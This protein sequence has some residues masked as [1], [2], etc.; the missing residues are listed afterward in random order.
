MDVG[1]FLKRRADFIRFF[2]AESIRPFQEIQ[3]RIENK[4][5]PFDDPPYSEDP[6]PAYLKEWMNA[7]TAID[8]VGLSCVSLLSDALKMYFNTLQH[9][10]IGFKI[11]KE[12]HAEAKRRGFVLF[13]KDALGI[14]L[15]TDWQDCPA[16]L[17]VIEQVVLARNRSQ[18]GD[19]ITSHH[20]THDAATLRKHP[21]P[22]FAS[23]D[24]LKSWEDSGSDEQSYFAPTLEITQEKF[25]AATYE[26]EKLA[27]WIESRM[28]K[29]WQWRHNA[30][31]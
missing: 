10:Q 15:D 7:R 16:N 14:V 2:Y 23:D 12:A 1:F 30:R 4:L 21:R 27:D 20:V 11:T 26:I 22:F 31:T 8:V 6:E 5:S 9:R 3:H 18:H 17:D 13:Y 25:V 28:D 29:A 24:E 19:D